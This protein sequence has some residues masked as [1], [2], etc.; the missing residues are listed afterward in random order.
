MFMGV[1]LVLA[2]NWEVPKSPYLGEWLKKLVD[3][4]CCCCCCCVASVVYDCAT[5]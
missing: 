4:Y 3:P 5:P 1:L 2:K